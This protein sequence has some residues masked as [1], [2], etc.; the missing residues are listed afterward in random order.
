MAGTHHQLPDS[1]TDKPHLVIPTRH[2]REVLVYPNPDILP[3][4]SIP[5]ETIDII[6]RTLQNSKA[7]MIRRLKSGSMMVTFK[8][9]ATEYKKGE[10]WITE[11]FRTNTTYICRKIMVLRKGLPN[12]DITR[13]YIDPEG[14]FDNLKRRNISN[15]IRIKLRYLQKDTIYSILII[16]C[17]NIQAV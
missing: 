16:N 7:I 5:S 15:I 12:R 3:A 1:G 17:N 10:N 2:N 9:G 6:N 11:I 8:E 14:L 13:A 4:S